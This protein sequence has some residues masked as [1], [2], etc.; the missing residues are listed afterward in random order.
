LTGLVCVGDSDAN[1]SLATRQATLDVDA[2][3][4]ITCTYTNKQDATVTIIK[5]AVPDDPQDFGYTVSGAGLSAFTLDDDGNDGNGVA[6]DFNN[7]TVFTIG[8]SDFG[9]KTVT[10]TLPVTGWDLTALAC[11]EGTT[12]LT[13]GVASFTVDP[14][15]TIT[16]TYTNTKRG[17]VE[18]VKTV[19][20]AAPGGMTFTFQIRT[21]ASADAVGTVVAS[22]T[23]DPVTGAANFG[24]LLLQPGTYQFCETN[25]MPG[26]DTSLDDGGFGAHFV[27]AGNLPD[28][29]NST[30]CVTFTLDPGET[31]VFNVN[32][33]PPPGG[34]ARTIGFWKNW[35]SCDGNGNQAPVLDQTLTEA[36]GSIL[37][38]DLVV[39]TCQ[40]AVRILNKSS[41][42]NGKKQANDAA[43]GLAAQLLAAKLNVV[44][45]AGTCAAAT[46]AI[47]AGQ[48]LLDGIGFNGTGSYLGPKV[49]GA[50]L[51]TR[52]TAN[53]LAATLDA[54]N[55]NELCP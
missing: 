26:W 7:E 28:P 39:D 52:N 50:M 47:A 51:A 43:Y 21:G 29:D 25:M 24:G 10:E 2:G 35:T 12:N 16:C 42:N 40:E 46:N 54:Y 32:N 5:N 20:G 31:Q 17:K 53:S 15:D 48:A 11:S 30:I 6:G 27:P 49:K 45:D 9:A 23:T 8:G 36:G 18:V 14:G 19:S 44:A 37:I 22:A 33:V 55:N 34:D 4:S 41:V 13:T 38:G 3:E 1:V